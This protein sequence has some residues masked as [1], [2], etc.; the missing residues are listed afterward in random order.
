MHRRITVV[1]GTV[2][3]AV[4]G[5]GVGPAVA[6]PAFEQ[7]SVSK[8]AR[9]ERLELQ[10]P[11]EGK[12]MKNSHI[13]IFLPDGFEPH[14]CSAAAGWSCSVPADPHDPR[15]PR[16]VFS[17]DGCTAESSWRCVHSESEDES[18]YLPTAGRARI[19]D[20]DDEEAENDE[21]G[22][23]FEFE[24]DVP[25]EAGTYAFPVTQ[26]Q[27]NPVDSEKIEWKGSDGSGHPAPTLTVQ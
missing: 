14:E 11:A 10:I 5:L 8:G 6:K 24:V 23:D 18:A 7:A 20:R 26:Y 15:R 21:A 25:N 9:E 27:A 2:A 19:A 17:R 4:A 16:V 22:N 13:E 1:V 12:G 3:V